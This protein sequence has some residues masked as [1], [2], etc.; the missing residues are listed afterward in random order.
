MDLVFLHTADLHGRLDATAHER[1]VALRTRASYYFDCGD[2]VK[3]GN[4]GIPTRRDAAWERL[5]QARCDAGVPGNR[6]FHVSSAVFRRKLRG[7]RHPLLAANMEWNG[8]DRKPLLPLPKDA[9][10]NGRQ[11]PLAS[12]MT[13]GDIG[14]FGVMV[15]MV[16]ERMVARTVSAFLHLDPVEAARECV[17]WLRPRCRVLIG[18][19]H[20]GLRND[21][22]LAEEVPGVDVILGGHSHDLLEQPLKV[23]DTWI[24]HIGA[25]AYF[26]GLHEFKHGRL[27]THLEPLR[28]PKT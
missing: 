19:T 11:P 14:L 23:G 15:P 6:E 13:L 5:A 3:S 26:A 17:R 22:R 8:R 10:L 25:H 24:A 21:K 27:R 9:L 18:L 7:C 2:A 20:I 16:T 12:A 4:V 1:L 28:S